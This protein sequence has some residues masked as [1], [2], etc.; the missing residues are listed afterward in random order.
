MIAALVAGIT[1]GTAGANMMPVLLDD[2]VARF[3][4]SPSTAGLLAAGQLLAVA[5]ATLAF[6]RRATRPGRAALAQRGLLLAAGGAVT[7]A[8]AAGPLLLILGNLVFGA[9]LGA[10]YAATTAALAAVA[11][12]DRTASLSIG[13]TVITTALLLVAV[14]MAGPGNGFPLLALCCLLVLPLTPS[15][16]DS[17]TEAARGARPPLV[18]LLGMGLLAAASQGPWSYAA[19]L[20]RDTG[21]PA[22]A[23]TGILALSAIGPLA[24]AALSPLVARRLG[25]GSTML[26]LMAGQAVSMVLLVLGLGPAVFTLAAVLWQAF[27]VA[28]LIQLLAA[29]SEVDGSGHLVA[30]LSGAGAIGNALG[31][32]LAGPLLQY[33]GTL[34]FG[35]AAALAT[36][37]A[38]LPLLRMA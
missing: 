27:Q 11:D 4:L 29:G 23:V 33:G 30:M 7:A 5:L 16:P 38:T 17:P 20:G 35:A 19:I 21:L 24:G 22:D 26:L 37:L 28:L 18:L 31:P 13:I 34:T 8:L 10:V 12:P 1:L 9:G 25:R 2:F 6:A 3:G 36:V 32:L 15:L 14:P